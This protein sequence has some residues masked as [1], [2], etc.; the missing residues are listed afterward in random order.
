MDE[1]SD[2][3]PD[4]VLPPYPKEVGV[5]VEK[6]SLNKFSISTDGMPYFHIDEKT[7]PPGRSVMCLFDVSPPETTSRVHS[8]HMAL[9]DVGHKR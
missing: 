2:A 1:P 7:T 8:S 5:A 6:S 4:Y 9:S 3:Q